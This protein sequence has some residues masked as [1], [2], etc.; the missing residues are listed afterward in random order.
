MIFHQYLR[1]SRVI[2]INSIRIL[3]EEEI[4]K[5]TSV[6]P[7]RVQKAQQIVRELERVTPLHDRRILRKLSKTIHGL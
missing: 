3:V 1:N 5:M 7:R 4:Y 2:I 6:S